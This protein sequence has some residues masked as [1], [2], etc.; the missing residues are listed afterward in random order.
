[1][2]DRYASVENKCAIG[3]SSFLGVKFIAAGGASP[4]HA[5][6]GVGAGAIG[7]RFFVGA[8]PPQNDSFALRMTGFLRHSELS[9]VILNGEAVKNLA[10]G[11][12]HSERSE[13]SRRGDRDEHRVGRSK[14]LPYRV[15][16]ARVLLE[17]DSSSA[18][19]LLR[20]TRLP[21]E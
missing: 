2:R 18:C 9:R 11:L 17:R 7:T 13:E 3:I 5:V 20:M 15:W 14:P 21:S 8:P 6:C 4:S 12:C 16:R 1:M 10:F 19:R